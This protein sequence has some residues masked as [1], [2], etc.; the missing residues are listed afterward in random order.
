MISEKV[1]YLALFPQIPEKIRAKYSVNGLFLRPFGVFKDDL[2]INFNQKTHPFLVTQILQCCTSD[3]N[4]KMPEQEFFWDLTVGKRIECLVAIALL[5]DLPKLS[6]H[7]RCSNEMCQQP[8]EI[9]IF[10]MEITNL[11]LK[12]D[13][14][15]SFIIR[16]GEKSLPIRKPTGRDQIEWLKTPFAN[17]DAAIQRMTRSLLCEGEKISPDSDMEYPISDELAKTVD[18][19]MEEFDPLVNFHLMV[20][21]PYCEKEGRYKINLEELSLFKL[22]KAQRN[23]LQTVHRLAFYYHWSEDDIFSIST[24][25]R[26]HYLDLIERERIQ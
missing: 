12:S 23:L 15:D 5:W 21:C 3:K 2:N 16:I 17:E 20:Y 24:W 8:M 19:S 4:G 22:H 7:L 10:Q 1:G 25:R 9:D 14:A 11:Q 18:E 6:V 13:K 26:L